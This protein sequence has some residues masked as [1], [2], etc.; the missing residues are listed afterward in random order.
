MEESLLL[1]AAYKPRAWTRRAQSIHGDVT[2]SVW[3]RAL[4]CR[5]VLLPLGASLMNRCVTPSLVIYLP[6]TRICSV[7]EIWRLP[8]AV[9]VSCAS[10][11]RWWSAVVGSWSVCTWLHLPGLRFSSSYDRQW[12]FVR[13]N[14][15]LDKSRSSAARWESKC[16]FH[17]LGF[18]QENGA[19]TWLFQ[20]ISISW[21]RW[22][23]APFGLCRIEPDDWTNWAPEAPSVVFPVVLEAPEMKGGFP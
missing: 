6:G 10:S 5:G 9:T 16:A 17:V 4:V 23:R 13:E 1:K 7:S 3:G 19:K 20:V 2:K 15:C 14:V 21:E 18:K 12:A 11:S 22:E 8:R